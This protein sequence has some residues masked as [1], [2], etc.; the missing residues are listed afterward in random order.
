M[1]VD[2]SRLEVG[3]VLVGIE[4]DR[5]IER[6][7]GGV[8]V[9][10]LAENTGQRVASRD[11][12]GRQ[13]HRLLRCGNGFRQ[14]I[15]LGEALAAND[16]RVRIDRRQTGGRV[17]G[18]QRFG[19]C[20]AGLLNPA[21]KV[22]MPRLAGASLY[23]QPANGSGVVQAAHLLEHDRQPVV[24]LGQCGI[25]FTS[26]AERR[27]GEHRPLSRQQHATHQLVSDR[28]IPVELRSLDRFSQRAGQIFNRPRPLGLGKARPRRDASRSATP[29]GEDLDRLR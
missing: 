12:F 26:L 19:E 7:E 20:A 17:V 13:K 11:A 8:Q 4:L 3:G 22:P 29:S 28:E 21:Q 14:A 2:R 24:R 16:V 18:G 27:L 23:R 25:E 6:L 1:Q 9:A 15:E 10:G 5:Q